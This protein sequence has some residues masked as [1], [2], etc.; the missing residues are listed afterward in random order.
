MKST[1]SDIERE[2]CSSIENNNLKK[3]RELLSDNS[4]NF[5]HHTW[6]DKD[7]Y[8][9]QCTTFIF[10]A[11]KT[12][13]PMLEL[14]IEHGITKYINTI[15][16]DGNMNA[17]TPIQTAIIKNDSYKAEL[18]VK[19]GAIISNGFGYFTQYQDHIMQGNSNL[20]VKLLKLT[21]EE[22]RINTLK[23]AASRKE[24]IEKFKLPNSTKLLKMCD[25]E[26]IIKED[27]PDFDNK[28]LINNQIKEVKN[29]G[30]NLIGETELFSD[31]LSEI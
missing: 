1:Y 28:K 31:E 5:N 10:L 3:V 27:L 17:R 16:F 7:A 24:V 21:T 22:D 19:A 23:I 11:V 2:M 26:K 4:T 30:I 25:D 20:L 8:G 14:L 9:T 6:V 12:S 13:N 18:L 29:S 15:I